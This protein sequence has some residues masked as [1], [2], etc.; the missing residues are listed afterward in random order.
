MV[1]HVKHILKSG[2]LMQ[3][4]KKHRN[5]E[6]D[7]FVTIL[8]SCQP[9]KLRRCHIQGIVLLSCLKLL[10]HIVTSIKKQATVATA[11]ET[12]SGP[13]PLT[14]HLEDTRRLAPS[15]D[16]HLQKHK[17]QSPRSMTPESRP[18]STL[19][20]HLLL[21]QNDQEVHADVLTLSPV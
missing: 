4:K 12:S 8:K 20:R 5:T 18:P 7:N 3:K 15:T 11:T 21:S 9:L 14:F 2:F 13:W 17:R 16:T 19:H 6:K 1:I 10:P